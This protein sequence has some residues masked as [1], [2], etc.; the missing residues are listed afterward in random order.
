MVC[1]KSRCQNTSMDF[2][3]VLSSAAC[4][5]KVCQR[6]VCF[7][8]ALRLPR[9][10]AGPA[11]SAPL[12]AKWV[13]TTPRLCRSL[14]ALSDPREAL[15]KPA[16]SLRALGPRPWAFASRQ[17]PCQVSPGR[18]VQRL[19][20]GCSAHTGGPWPPA[21]LLCLSFPVRSVKA[22]RPL[23]GWR[24]RQEQALSKV[25]PLGLSSPLSPLVFKTMSLSS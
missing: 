15:R 22:V 11:S 13:S 20:C 10:G 19:P 24:V 6:W 16:F 25:L 4:Q 7:P 18:E 5:G 23:E 21:P 8:L 2:S 1:L 3:R 9:G 17:H 12:L 14:H